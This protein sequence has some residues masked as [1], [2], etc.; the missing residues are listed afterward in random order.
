MLIL[1]IISA[2]IGAVVGGLSGTA[3]LGWIAGIFFFVVG[4]PGA[5]IGGFVHDSITY[6][7]DRA[8]DRQMLSDFNAD[9]RAIDHEIAEDLRTDKLIRSKKRRL[10]TQ[11]YND[12]R[13]VNVYGGS[14]EDSRTGSSNIISR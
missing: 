10:L 14:D 12:N 1:L 9:T 8:D 3:M 11:V 6:T 7:Q 13:Q 4:L 5:L 2:V